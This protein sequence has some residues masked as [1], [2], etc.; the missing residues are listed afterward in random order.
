[1]VLRL[2]VVCKFSLCSL[3]DSPL[4][5]HV[6]VNMHVE[7]WLSLLPACVYEHMCLVEDSPHTLCMLCEHVRLVSSSPII[8]CLA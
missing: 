8:L 2:H 1:M 6:Y 7:E 5:M 3:E 4:V